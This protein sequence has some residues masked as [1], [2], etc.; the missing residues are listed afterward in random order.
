MED[1]EL[2]K[3]EC[4]CTI[5][6]GI[7]TSAFITIEKLGRN[8]IHKLLVENYR[9]NNDILILPYRE[10]FGMEEVNI[11]WI[12]EHWSMPLTNYF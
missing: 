11:G 4:T 3:L 7:I 8:I 1:L 5:L 9:N 6:C 2:Y 12:P 10:I